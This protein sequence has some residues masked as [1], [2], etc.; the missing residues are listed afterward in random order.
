MRKEIDIKIGPDG[1]I[2]IEL[3]N[4][5]G[6]GCSKIAQQFVEALGR[7]VES[8]RKPEFYDDTIKNDGCQ[9]NQEGF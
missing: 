1:S 8:N 4:F 9:R 6:D 3:L 2:E 5:K 7:N